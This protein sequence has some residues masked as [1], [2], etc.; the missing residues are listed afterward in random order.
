MRKGS[1]A[2]SHKLE[3]IERFE[4]MREMMGERK[5]ELK[6]YLHGIYSLAIR[7]ETEYES[8]TNMVTMMMYNDDDDCNII[9]PSHS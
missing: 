8:Y 3:S 9:T 4:A 2:S 6:S 7:I 1:D 5:E